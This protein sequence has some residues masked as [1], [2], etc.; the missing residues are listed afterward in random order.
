[1]EALP[2]L[3]LLYIAAHLSGA[4][5]A[6][7][8]AVSRSWRERLNQDDFWRHRCDSQTAQY[9]RQTECQVQPFFVNPEEEEST[10][11]S[12][13]CEWRLAYMRQIHLWNNWRN[14]RYN[15]VLVPDD[16][17]YFTHSHQESTPL[18]IYKNE[19]L[20]V[21]DRNEMQL[22]NFEESAVKMCVK[23]L[24]SSELINML[25]LSGDSVIVKQSNLL[26]MFDISIGKP[27]FVL[28]RSVVTSEASFRPVLL[29]HSILIEV[30]ADTCTMQVWN[31]DTGEKFKEET[32]ENA[33][34]L[35]N[36][37]PCSSETHF[38][39][40]ASRSRAD[41]I[42][43]FIL[44]YRLPEVVL[45]FTSKLYND[46]IQETL[47][48]KDH[49][50][51]KFYN[52]IDSWCFKTGQ[53]IKQVI[54]RS[55][56][57]LERFDNK[58]C[59]IDSRGN[60]VKLTPGLEEEEVVLANLGYENI[61]LDRLNSKYFLASVYGGVYSRI[62]LGKM[63]GNQPSRVV[64]L[65]RFKDLRN[66]AVNAAKSVLLLSSFAETDRVYSADF[67]EVFEAVSFW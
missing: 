55:G 50:F 47:I 45:V 48:V 30:Q 52:F 9:L 56:T 18:L 37:K 6:A 42:E 17:H 27:E 33:K 23:T 11:L 13:I 67:R 40:T 29:F 32:R 35:L 20:I 22:W 54:I 66:F 24:P 49:V 10:G 41:N 34:A 62:W 8:C 46:Y 31:I 2:D 4:E 38:A 26:L 44:V 3:A 65:G 19:F 1:M 12:D 57:N 25:S 28:T 60:L 63:D 64:A 59:F 5:L 36:L 7:W 43:Y 14:N 16:T 15:S 21:C 51:M 58:V 61:C 53:H 39:L